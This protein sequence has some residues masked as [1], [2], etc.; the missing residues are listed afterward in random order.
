MSSLDAMILTLGSM[1][2]RDVLDRIGPARSDRSNVLWGK[3]F[4]LSVAIVVYVL[5]QLL[6]R[7]VFDIAA[8]AFAGFVTLT[9]TLF[10]GLRWSRFTAAAAI[11]SLVAGNVVLYLGHF[12]V[13]PL[14]GFLPVFWAFLAALATAVAVSL[15]SD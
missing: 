2:T 3:A 6:G 8:L 5:A 4:G 1:L 11:A 9:P 13:I 10:L 12:E 14:F 7:S 15:V